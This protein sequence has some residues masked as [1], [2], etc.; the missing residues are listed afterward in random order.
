[1]SGG[2]CAGSASRVLQLHDPKASPSHIALRR[3]PTRKQAPL[4]YTCALFC[5]R[6]GLSLE[7]T[8]HE[9]DWNAAESDC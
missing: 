5:H 4:H 6:A 7:L 3:P 9:L 2:Y 8:T 1:L